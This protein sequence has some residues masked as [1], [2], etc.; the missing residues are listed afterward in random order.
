MLSDALLPQ[1]LPE[2]Q[3]QPWLALL[4]ILCVQTKARVLG[5]LNPVCANHKFGWLGV[6][7]YFKSN[8]P[9]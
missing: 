1:A 4:L 3:A 5:K 8:T 2:A 6:G 7:F 9:P